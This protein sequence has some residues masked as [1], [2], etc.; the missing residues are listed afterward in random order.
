MIDMDATIAEL[1]AIG[2]SGVAADLRDGISPTTV[3]SRL[4]RL[5]WEDGEDGCESEDYDEVRSIVADL[6]ATL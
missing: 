3:L 6:D 4:D 1:D 5:A 2:W